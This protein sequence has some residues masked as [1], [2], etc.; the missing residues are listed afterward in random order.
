[1][2]Y[3][4]YSVE[5]A[6]TLMRRVF[7]W[8][9]TGLL[10]T[11]GTAYAVYAIP[12]LHAIFFGHPGIMIMLVLAQLGLVIY[13]SAGITRMSAS[14][15]TISYML[16]AIL[17]GA[18]FST[19]LAQFTHESLALTFLVCAGMFAAMALYGF[20]TRSD[21]SGM[22]TY[23]LMGLFGLIIAS[24]I[25]MFVLSAKMDFTI[26]IIGVALFTLL[27]AFDVQRIKHLGMSMI[28]NDEDMA[29]VAILCALTLYLDFINLFLY[30]LRF[31]G[32]KKD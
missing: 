5:N 20:L 3:S 7:G 11:A 15:A 24:V 4:E 21:L 23:L 18:T 25:N 30:L 9:A 16:Y 8:M 26:A 13:L 17:T 6:S 32:Q 31:L 12:T 1:M 27:T 10:A 28:A 29:K 14:T 19:L 2:I 22:G